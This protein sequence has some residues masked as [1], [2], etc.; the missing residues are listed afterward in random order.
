MV[1]IQL[2]TLAHEISY[3]SAGNLIDSR[4]FIL[5]DAYFIVYDRWWINSDKNAKWYPSEK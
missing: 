1:K 2:I 3:V 5:N 4:L